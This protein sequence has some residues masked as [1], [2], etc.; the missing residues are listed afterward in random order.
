MSRLQQQFCLCAYYGA[1]NPVVCVVGMIIHQLPPGPSQHHLSLLIHVVVWWAPR[2]EVP[3]STICCCLPMLW[4]GGL[5]ES[6]SQPAPFVVVDSRCGVV[7]SSKG[8]PSQH[9]LLLLIHVVMRWAPR[10][11]LPVST[12][13]CGVVGSSKGLAAS[14]TIKNIGLP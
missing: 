13:S 5:L 11:E 2:K 10:K 6:R 3:A 4:C 14:T 9:H 12:T 7:R 1:S 8:G